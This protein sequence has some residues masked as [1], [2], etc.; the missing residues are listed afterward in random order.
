MATSHHL[1]W[2]AGLPLL[3]GGNVI[4][5]IHGR[6]RFIQEHTVKAVLSVSQQS[7]TTPVLFE[8]NQAE[9]KHR[10]FQSDADFEQNPGCRKIW[11]HWLRFPTLT[12]L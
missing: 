6:V 3:H 7:R 9:I 10:L 11:L 4:R 8:Q 2:Q 12:T 1:H 5:G